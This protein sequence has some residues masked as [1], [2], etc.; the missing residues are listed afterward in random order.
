MGTK[1]Q[2]YK[3]SETDYRRAEFANHPT[4]LKGNNELLVLTQPNIIE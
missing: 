1:V 4:D 2:T 3:L